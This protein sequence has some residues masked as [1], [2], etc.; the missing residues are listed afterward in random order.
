M[1]TQRRSIVNRNEAG[2]GGPAQIS[3][4]QRRKHSQFPAPSDGIIILQVVDE[5]ILCFQS[6]AFAAKEP[7]WSWPRPARSAE[8]H[9]PADAANPPSR[10]ATQTRCQLP[11]A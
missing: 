1:A 5:P 8:S 4:C 7:D 6:A 11:A 2:P 9:R 3:L 10:L